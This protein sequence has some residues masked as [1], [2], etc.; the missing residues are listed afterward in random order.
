[1][2]VLGLGT[3]LALSITLAGVVAAKYGGDSYL[4]RAYLLAVIVGFSLIA[5]GTF[6]LLAL[7]GWSRRGPTSP[8]TDPKT[9]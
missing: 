3:L 9:A 6:R 2:L 7:A 4:F 5:P 8:S 1:M